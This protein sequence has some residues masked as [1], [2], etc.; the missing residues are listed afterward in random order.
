MTAGLDVFDT[1]I[2]KPGLWL[3]CPMPW[4]KIENRRPACLLLR[5][6]PPQDLGRPCVGRA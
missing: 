6:A 2:P 3:E 1:T 5:A 4:L